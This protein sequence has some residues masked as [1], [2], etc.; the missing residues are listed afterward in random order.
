MFNF[1]GLDTGISTILP[2][3]CY[4]LDGTITMEMITIVCKQSFN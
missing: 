4:P 2:E 3:N 1:V